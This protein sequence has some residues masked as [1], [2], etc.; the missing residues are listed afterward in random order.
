MA[1]SQLPMFC[2][3][4]HQRQIEVKDIPT[5]VRPRRIVSAFK[6]LAHQKGI[7]V[8]VIDNGNNA[9]AYLDYAVCIRVGLAPIGATI[10]FNFRV[11]TNFRIKEQWQKEL[12]CLKPS[13]SKGRLNQRRLDAL[14]SN[15]MRT[16]LNRAF[17][18]TL[19]IGRNGDIDHESQTPWP[20][21]KTAE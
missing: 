14:H 5:V 8:T 19:A 13:G 6:W 7:D 1:L 3:I 21:L 9:G 15:L 11:I 2:A 10:W 4:Q 12:F 16:G 18:T 17:R 20:N